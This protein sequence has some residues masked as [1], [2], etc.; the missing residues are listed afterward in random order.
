M[1]LPGR[2]RA[3]ED[4]AH[5]LAGDWQDIPLGPGQEP[6]GPRG[7][8]QYDPATGETRR[9]PDWE[10]LVITDLRPERPA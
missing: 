3:T 1:N 5:D 7:H 2:L 6:A 10:S 9:H 8:L 4:G